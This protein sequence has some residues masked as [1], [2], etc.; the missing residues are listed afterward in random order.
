[1]AG[2]AFVPGA[3]D[4]VR[5]AVKPL[6]KTTPTSAVVDATAR[7]GNRAPDFIVSP[8][9]TAFPVPKGA[10]GPF[11]AD[12]GKGFKFTGGAGGHGL[13]PEASGVR[14]M[15]PTTTGKYQYP[16][17]YG[18]YQNAV[19]QTINPYTGQTIS[20]SNPWWHVPAE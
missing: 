2:V 17:G 20:K 15:D 1:M 6:L 16:T 7:V 19:G 3:G 14:L 13:S 8:G 12:S 5:S 9:G 18:S 10:I 4:L 11:P